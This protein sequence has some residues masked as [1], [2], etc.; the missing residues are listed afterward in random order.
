M[1]LTNLT[2]L[3]SFPAINL[4][5]C[6]STLS[7]H[8]WVHFFFKL[9]AYF[10]NHHPYTILYQIKKTQVPQ[11]YKMTSLHITDIFVVQYLDLQPFDE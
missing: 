6:F 2:Q 9:Y 3:T 5:V 10:L 1:A 11:T 4:L 8:N 7:Y